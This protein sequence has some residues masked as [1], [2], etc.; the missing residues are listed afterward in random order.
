MRIISWKQDANA[1]RLKRIHQ[2]HRRRLSEKN[3]REVVRTVNI[4]GKFLLQSL[5][6][7]MIMLSAGLATVELLV[8]LHV[9]TSVLIY[10]CIQCR[11]DRCNSRA[12][13]R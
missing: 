6:G 3:S 1:V 12:L 13:E 7:L 2:C 11:T 4:V 9:V 5:L 10:T 8:Q